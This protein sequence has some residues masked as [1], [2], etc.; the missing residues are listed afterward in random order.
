MLNTE[1]YLGVV[2]LEVKAVVYY[3][4]SLLKNV[5]LGTPDRRLNG[6]PDKVRGRVD[7]GGIS[8]VNSWEVRW[9]RARLL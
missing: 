5:L 9:L 2:L 8:S 3:R 7:C 4:L 6:G 1:G